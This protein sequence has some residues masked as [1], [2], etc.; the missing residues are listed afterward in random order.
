MNQPIDD[1]HW[2]EQKKPENQTLRDYFAASE[3]LGDIDSMNDDSALLAI[4]FALGGPKPKGSWSDNPV[5][6]I[7]WNARWRAELRYIRA[8]AMIEAREAK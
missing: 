6:W 5:G 3:K 2:N 7:K 8:D 4:G 1:I